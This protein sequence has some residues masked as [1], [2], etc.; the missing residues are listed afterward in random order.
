MPVSLERLV[1]EQEPAVI[2]EELTR[3]C[4]QV[5]LACR[6]CRAR[7]SVR[8]LHGRTRFASAQGAARSA[9][10]RRRPQLPPRP[11]TRPPR[12]RRQ[13]TG[14]DADVAEE[15]RKQLPFNEV[16]ALALS[17]RRLARITSLH[18]F[19][20]LTRLRLDNNRIARI[21]GIGHLVGRASGKRSGGGARAVRP[22]RAAA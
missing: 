20:K 16:E 13:V 2:T 15:K 1:A 12:P 6:V 18:G 3:E 8:R 11:A 4:I 5:G 17:F 7:T 21:E 19:D 9:L 22:T 14:C 10:P